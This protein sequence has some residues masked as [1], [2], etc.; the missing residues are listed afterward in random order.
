MIFLIFRNNIIQISMP[1]Y[2]MRCL[3]TQTD[4]QLTRA[5]DLKSVRTVRSE[6]KRFFMKL[7][8]TE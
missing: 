3:R 2:R 6:F 8:E 1:L 4:Y 7:K 5:R